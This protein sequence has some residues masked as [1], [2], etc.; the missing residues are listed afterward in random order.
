MI[1]KVQHKIYWEINTFKPKKTGLMGK[2]AGIFGH[3]QNEVH[4][5]VMDIQISSRDGDTI[6]SAL[7]SILRQ[8][9]NMSASDSESNISAHN[10]IRTIQFVRNDE[11]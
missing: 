9:R 6:D 1:S 8:L 5:Y 7:G 10:G 4:K 2:V 3:T 11:L